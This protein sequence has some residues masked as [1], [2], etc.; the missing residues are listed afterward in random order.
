[1]Y[2][3][4]S[5]DAPNLSMDILNYWKTPGDVTNIP[6]LINKSNTAFFPGGT[7]QF[8]DYTLSRNSS[9]FLEDGSFVRLK[10]LT[11]G[12]NFPK[13]ILKR[14]GIAESRIKLYAEM[15]NVFIITKYSGIDPE[16][17]AYGPSVLQAGYDEITMPN[18]KTFR[19]GFKIGL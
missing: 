2:G 6:A 15:N 14:I 13:A 12:Y 8:F 7:T 19:F 17:S 16:V 5:P 4:S 10:N 1:M 3:F 9:R 18:P 11:M